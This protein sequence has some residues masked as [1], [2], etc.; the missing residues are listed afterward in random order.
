M[1]RLLN[2][3]HNRELSITNGYLYILTFSG[4]QYFD[5][6]AKFL[7]VFL[8]EHLPFLLE[9]HIHIHK[10][11]DTVRGIIT[12]LFQEPGELSRRR[13]RRR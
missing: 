3:R 9:D 7:D 10:D 1:R 11:S 5:S 6:L 4:E 13:R 8:E 2:Q 12:D